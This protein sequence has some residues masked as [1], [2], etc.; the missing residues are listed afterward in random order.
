MAPNNHT[1]PPNVH[2]VTDGAVSSSWFSKA[3]FKGQHAAKAIKLQNLF[4]ELG[5]LPCYLTPL[6]GFAGE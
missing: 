4:T 6:L 5:I 1:L 2:L 3:F